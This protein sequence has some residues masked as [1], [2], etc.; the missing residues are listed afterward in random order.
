MTREVSRKREVREDKCTRDKGLSQRGG[1][2]GKGGDG[3]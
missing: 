2:G 1:G 3:S